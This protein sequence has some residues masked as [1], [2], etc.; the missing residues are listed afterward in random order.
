[1]KEVPETAA[2]LHPRWHTL[3]SAM[4]DQQQQQLYQ[5]VQQVQHA[6]QLL[7]L[8]QQQAQQQ[9]QARAAPSSTAFLLPADEQ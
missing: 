2:N 9:Q 3:V 7:Q 4:Y 6:Q 5:Q 1:M 8:Q